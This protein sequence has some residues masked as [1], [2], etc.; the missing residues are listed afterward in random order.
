MNKNCSTSLAIWEIQIKAQ[1]YF[2]TTRT[3]VIKKWTLTRACEN[4]DELQSSYTVCGGA[5]RYSCLGKQCLVV[6][7]LSRI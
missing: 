5:K 3:A 7:S 4:V 6:Q 1:Y 2:S